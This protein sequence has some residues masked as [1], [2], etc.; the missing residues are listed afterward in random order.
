MRR[1][2]VKSHNGKPVKDVAPVLDPSLENLAAVLE[3]IADMDA[4]PL[5]PSPR[6]RKGKRRG[7]T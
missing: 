4:L 5:A 6:P 2:P 1:K 7:A 3:Q